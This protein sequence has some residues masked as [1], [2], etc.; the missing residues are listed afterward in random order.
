[1]GYYLGV[2]IGTTY[3]A[4]GVW[5]DGRV[6]VATLGLRSPVVPSVV[7][8]RADGEVLVGDA[9]ERRAVAEPER[10]VREFKRRFGDPTPIVVGDGSV[11]VEALVAR[12][13]RWV[14]DR[15]AEAEGGPT[16]GVAVT[17][18]ANWGDYKKR[19]LRTAV[20]E[21]GVAAATLVTEPEAAAIHYTSQERVPDGAVV[22]VYDLGGGTFDAA[23]L[24]KEGARWRVLGE[25][26]GIERL[27]GVDF[28]E[29]VFRHVLASVADAV[30]ALDPD[31]P[32][33][34]TAMARLRHDCVEAKEALSA[35]T[36]VT[37]PV[38]LPGVHTEVRLTRAEFEEMV[39]PGLADTIAALERAVRSAG[40]DGDEV[41]RVLLVGGSSRIPL[42]GQL[43]GSALGRPVAVDAH[44]KYGVALGAA[45]VAAGVDVGDAADTSEVRAIE[46]S[47]APA[48]AAAAAAAGLAGLA[49]D[50]DAEADAGGGDVAAAAGGLAGPS[51]AA[52]AGDADTGSAGPAL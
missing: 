16:A 19:L 40:V 11:A 6:D 45:I 38:L 18:P 1:M 36:D 7:V 3:T 9:A 35:D 24:R 31:D 20:A 43:V 41:T 27:G 30:E 28:D 2:D 23:V 46:E 10:V 12:V 49:A 32:T 26:Q 52:G 47:P 5:R 15:V 39:R 29:A 37:I 34:R 13:L 51:P 33:A 44:P 42:V 48:A 17:H 22:A 25:P 8:A 14:V 4:A 50:P 21:A